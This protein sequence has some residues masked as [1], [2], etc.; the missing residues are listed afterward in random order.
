MH[1]IIHFAYGLNI[2]L[3]IVGNELH[4]SSHTCHYSL[5]LNSDGIPIALVQCMSHIIISSSL[6]SCWPS[7]KVCILSVP[8]TASD[9]R[10]E[11]CENSDP[12]KMWGYHHSV[13][14]YWRVV[15]TH[16]SINAF[17][18]M[19]TL[20]FWDRP[21][22]KNISCDQTVIQEIGCYVHYFTE[23]DWQQWKWDGI[24]SICWAVNHKMNYL[25]PVQRILLIN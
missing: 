6:N 2:K 5:H 21:S 10:V 17:C 9:L 8:Q 12:D 11:T 14:A 20:K 15:M 16:M 25:D 23:T 4:W 13:E 7:L 24:S 22:W 19:G 3:V 18:C 1:H